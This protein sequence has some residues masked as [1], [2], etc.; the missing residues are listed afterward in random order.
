MPKLF[1]VSATAAVALLVGGSSTPG[2]ARVGVQCGGFLGISCGARE[3]C[4]KPA[5]TCF[6]PDFGG[7]CV[8]VPTLC[9]KLFRPVCGCNGR[10][11]A[12]DC[13]RMVARVDKLHDGRCR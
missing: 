3:F 11:Y 12:N 1:A 2:L 7:R 6:L 8:R 10:T 5:G 13:E 4:E 9:P